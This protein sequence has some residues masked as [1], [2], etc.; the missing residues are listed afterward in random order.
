MESKSQW[1][2]KEL[3]SPFQGTIERTVNI[4]FNLENGYKLDEASRAKIILACKGM[5]KAKTTACLGLF[6][7][8]TF[9]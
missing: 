3:S 2:C 5:E 9:V 7:A 8:V 4:S 6:P 1:N